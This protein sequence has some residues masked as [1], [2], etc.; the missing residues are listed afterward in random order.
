[1]K[2][3]RGELRRLQNDKKR[4]AIA[5]RLMPKDTP[6]DEGDRVRINVRSPICPNATGY[7]AGFIT[8]FGQDYVRVAI[9]SKRGMIIKVDIA[10][11]ER[12]SEFTQD[13][14]LRGRLLAEQERARIFEFDGPRL[15]VVDRLR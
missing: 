1:M 10:H 13:A 6:I 2:T 12:Q 7:V 14:L 15:N 3:T 4:A 8:C 9:P 5:S 11:L